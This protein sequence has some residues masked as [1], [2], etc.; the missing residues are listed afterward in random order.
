MDALRISTWVF[1]ET[2]EGNVFNTFDT[3]YTFERLHLNKP[4][5]IDI[6]NERVLVFFFE[7][8]GIIEIAAENEDI[9]FLQRDVTDPILTK[10]YSY[11]MAR[12]GHFE[13]T[14]LREDQIGTGGAFWG[15]AKKP[16]AEYYLTV[17]A[18]KFETY[19]ENESMPHITARVKFTVIEDD[20]RG[21][22]DESWCYI[23]ELVSYEYSELEYLFR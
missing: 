21:I 6:Y 3:V 13:I 23:I 20:A 22:P 12:Q 2:V 10:R 4:G 7:Y 14:L 15:G 16:G 11:T 18:Y 17:R 8:D 5:L 1:D 19:V 9:H